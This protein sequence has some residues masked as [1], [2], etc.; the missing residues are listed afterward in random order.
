MKPIW[1]WLVFSVSALAVL[2]VVGW[3]G[4]RTIRLEEAQRESRLEERRDEAA[5]AALRRMEHSIGMRLIQEAGRRYFDYAAVYDPEQPYGSMLRGRSRPE[6]VVPSVLLGPPTSYTKLH[7]QLH[8]DGELTS[9]Q[10]PETWMRAAAVGPFVDQKTVDAAEESLNALRG[11]FR[12]HPLRRVFVWE[13]EGLGDES[14]QRSGLLDERTPALRQSLREFNVRRA[15]SSER[16]DSG[17][18]R[19]PK[20]ESNS[21][22][23][24]GPVRTLWCGDALLLARHVRIHEDPYI[25]G[26]WLDWA[27]IRTQLQ[28]DIEDL[29]PHARL[30]PV[31]PND[32]AP[33]ELRMALLPVQLIPGPL[34]SEGAENGSSG[35]PGPVFRSTIMALVAV[36]VA[37]V[38]IAVLIHVILSFSARRAEFTSAVT[39]ELR[40]PLTTLRMYTDLLAS[41]RVVDE[42]KRRRYFETLRRE[43]DRLGRLVENV[44]AFSRLESGRG[45][46][47][48]RDVTLGEL[49]G[50]ISE[51]CRERV[52][53]SGMILE[54]EIS[55]DARGERVR[56]DPAGVEHVVFNL[57]DNAAKYAAEAGD[58]RVH[59]GAEVRSPR[60]SVIWVRDHGPGLSDGVLRNLFRAFTR[61]SRKAARD[62][63]GVGLGLALG[64]K[65][66]RSIGGDLVHDERVLDGARFELR[67][68]RR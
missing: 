67:L 61:A 27:A 59:L 48:L 39:H 34:G 7:F 68:P 30:L 3:T 47:R 11:V 29:L 56:T 49:I 28:K 32:S 52:E 41:G 17:S 9:P 38:A 13:E 12:S 53:S 51:R 15:E 64:R 58:K 24:I 5:S 60:R 40:T 10:V 16:R 1:V 6:T 21:P 45:G 4:V 18:V 57:I 43:A 14:Y 19:R 63:P 2:L 65:I 25:Q 44:L 36:L 31:R 37:A 35:L 50:D 42:T 46:A 22:V 33:G 55:P 20:K 62:K 8:P 66:A 54:V 23:G 26:A